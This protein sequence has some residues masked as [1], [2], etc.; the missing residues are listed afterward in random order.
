[1]VVLVVVVVLL[2][3]LVVVTKSRTRSTLTTYSSC[4][5]HGR[6]AVEY[7]LSRYLLCLYLLSQAAAGAARHGAR[8]AG[9]C[10]GHHAPTGRAPRERALTRRA[11]PN[12][13]PNSNPNP[14]VRL[15]AAHTAPK[16]LSTFINDR[17]NIHLASRCDSTQISGCTPSTGCSS[18]RCPRA[19]CHLRAVRRGAKAEQGA[20]W[21]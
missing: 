17:A 5:Y 12:P 15:R 3:L 11:N 14:N 19:T 2:L 10:G 20:E 6:L 13:D 18:R 16:T 8:A 1:M 9:A 21:A 4:T 7:L